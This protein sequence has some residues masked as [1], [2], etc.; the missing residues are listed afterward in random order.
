MFLTIFDVNCPLILIVVPAILLTKIAS[1]LPLSAASPTTIPVVLETSIS[2]LPILISFTKFSPNALPSG[3]LAIAVTC[4]PVGNAAL[5]I[6]APTSGTSPVNANLFSLCCADKL[7]VIVPF[8][9]L[10]NTVNNG[11]PTLAP[12]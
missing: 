3:V 4:V 9:P 7:S 10:L 1:P 8:V 6:G 2:V 5:T 11:C 12:V